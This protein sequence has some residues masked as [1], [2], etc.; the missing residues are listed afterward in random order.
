MKPVSCTAPTVERLSEFL[1]AYEFEFLIAE[2][3][4]GA[5]YK[6]RQRSLDRDVA[7]KILPHG[8]GSDPHFREAFES[9]AKAMARLSHPNL[10]K[11]F[12]YGDADGLLYKV[13]EYVHGKSLHHSSYGHRIEI[14]QAVE[15]AIAACQGIAHAHANGIVH[16][17]IKPTSILLTKKCEPKIGD[18]G[19]ARPSNSPGENI[20][21][22]PNG[23]AAPEAGGHSTKGDPR[24]D[25]FSI[26]IILKELLTGIHPNAAGFDQAVLGDP[27]LAK[28]YAKATAADPAMRYPTIS[29]FLQALE[30]WSQPRLITSYRP[31]PRPAPPAP[32][33]AKQ[34]NWALLQNLAVISFLLVAIAFT[35]NLY[36]RKE[37]IIAEQTRAASEAQA[38]SAASMS[39]AA[40]PSTPATLTAS[41]RN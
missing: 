3:S 25:I 12:D 41:N 40:T 36:Q 22:D 17:N 11:V 30:S 16:R 18:F 9:K 2:G 27:R 29:D 7:I 13:M 32:V 20:S 31:A 23:Y 38:K 10:I 4:T 35:W 24:S 14:H 28:I 26:G 37:A 15:I 33:K 1:P 5:I 19:V 6:A 8:L 21:S 39:S 34:V